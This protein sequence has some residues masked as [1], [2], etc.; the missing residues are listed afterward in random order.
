MEGPA[1]R[2]WEL[3]NK[4][5]ASGGRG[6][7]RSKQYSDVLKKALEY[8][9]TL[10]DDPYH[11]MKGLTLYELLVKGGRIKGVSRDEVVGL[12]KQI[13]GSV[14][15]T[16][17]E[18]QVQLLSL[19]AYL[20]YHA[21]D[22]ERWTLKPKALYNLVSK[23]REFEDV[24][25]FALE[26]VYLSLPYKSLS[27]QGLVNL[28]R[29]EKL[30][31]YAELAKIHDFLATCNLVTTLAPSIH[32]LYL[33]LALLGIRRAGIRPGA[34]YYL[35]VTNAAFYLM[36]RFGDLSSL[37]PKEIYQ[38][39]SPL[40][41]YYSTLREIALKKIEQSKNVNRLA[42]VTIVDVYDYEQLLPPPVVIAIED[43]T[44]RSFLLKHEVASMILWL[45]G[46]QGL[47]IDLD[48]YI[49]GLLKVT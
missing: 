45:A 8:N 13:F 44:L 22:E 46:A 18:Y 5:F 10:I 41:K 7:I 39:L 47:R 19:F 30:D 35:I 12:W 24:W 36:K 49:K 21:T 33:F 11:A 16:F 28:E 3:I 15:Q 31:T 26:R 14:P 42:G 40:A 17:H 9:A 37:E 48:T 1:K 34:A 2:L 4:V 29:E 6:E 38:E 20:Y 25:R 43:P 23:L 27:L 32:R